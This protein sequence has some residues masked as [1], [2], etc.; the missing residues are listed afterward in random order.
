[1]ESLVYNSIHVPL[2]Y[3]RPNGLVTLFECEGAI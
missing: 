1:M 2:F 3:N